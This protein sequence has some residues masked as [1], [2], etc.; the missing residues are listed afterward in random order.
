MNFVKET[1]INQ[2]MQPQLEMMSN[3]KQSIK[4]TQYQEKRNNSI[5]TK[6]KITRVA[7][8]ESPFKIT[9]IRANES[10]IYF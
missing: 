6:N 5:T 3:D 9:S 8:L 4:V 1:I 7:Y 10:R 2:K